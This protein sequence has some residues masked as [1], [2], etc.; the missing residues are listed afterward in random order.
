MDD[1][2]FGLQAEVARSGESGGWGTGFQLHDAGAFP[3]PAVIKGPAKGCEHAGIFAGG[4]KHLG[5]GG[6]VDGDAEDLQAVGHGNFCVALK[7]GIACS[8]GIV[9]AALF[10]KDPPELGLDFVE[11]GPCIGDAAM[12]LP[13]GHAVEVDRI[14]WIDMRE[15]PAQ[16][17]KF[18][19]DLSKPDQQFLICIVLQRF[20]GQ[21][22]IAGTP[23]RS[24]RRRSDVVEW[25]R[26]ISSFEGDTKGDNIGLNGPGGAAN[27]ANRSSR[28]R[29]QGL[30]QFHSEDCRAGAFYD[31]GAGLWGLPTFDMDD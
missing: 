6:I 23:D 20:R 1:P 22:Q 5:V 3:G 29:I 26:W 7:G 12:I 18:A 21:Q 17:A 30:G 27:F 14:L 10:V 8:G 19:P 16:G 15:K 2:G 4:V 31:R 25:N 13:G 28:N 11:F 9:S 24:G